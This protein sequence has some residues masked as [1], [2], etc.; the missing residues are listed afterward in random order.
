MKHND[1]ECAILKL[2]KLIFVQ[3]IVIASL[4]I[5]NSYCTVERHERDISL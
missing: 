1:L 5:L 3:T 4:N 2:Y